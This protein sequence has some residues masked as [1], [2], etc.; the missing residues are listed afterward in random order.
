MAFRSLTTCIVLAVTSS[1]SSVPMEDLVDGLSLIQVHARASVANPV[2]KLTAKVHD[3]DKPV[4]DTNIFVSPQNASLEDVTIAAKGHGWTYAH[5]E[6]WAHSFAACGGKRQSPIDIETRAALNVTRRDYGRY[7]NMHTH[8]PM[9]S[10]LSMVNNGHAVQVNGKYGKFGLLDMP[11][12]DGGPA[13]H[14]ELL[15]FHFH[16]PSEHMLNGRRAAGEMHL[17]HQKRGAKGTDGLAVVGVLLDVPK[18]PSQVPN[19]LFEKLNFLNLPGRL[20]ASG[21][22]NISVNFNHMLKDNFAGPY[23]TYSGSLTTPPCSENVKWIVLKRPLFVSHLAVDSFKTLFPN[24]M[25][26][27]PVQALYGRTVQCQGCRGGVNSATPA[28][29]TAVRSGAF[30]LR[31]HMLHLAMLPVAISLLSQRK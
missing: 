2:V 6:Q 9:V 11:Q 7:F 4:A 1:G 30:S 22:A 21:P 23:F 8:Y 12:H 18:N 13:T 16:F 3:S 25:N 26:N 14:W 10:G 5:P 19:D 27:R 28:T 15:Q 31:V 17:V 24:P 20:K 29:V